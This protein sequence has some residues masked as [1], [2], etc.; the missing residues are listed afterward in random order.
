MLKRIHH[1][2][3]EYVRLCNPK[4]RRVRE[5]C[6]GDV[7][8][9]KEPTIT[10]VNFKD[11]NDFFY[12]VWEISMVLSHLDGLGEKTRIFDQVRQK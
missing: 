10:T 2:L 7:V 6:D 4:N 3:T 9:G 12:C 1:I 5:I 11:C 8:F